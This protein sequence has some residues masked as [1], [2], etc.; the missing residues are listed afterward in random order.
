MYK[1]L[2]CVA[3]LLIVMLIGYQIFLI[4]KIVEWGS[5]HLFQLLNRCLLGIVTKYYGLFLA[6]DKNI[7]KFSSGTLLAVPDI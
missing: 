3:G 5:E 2:F 6:I 7:Y 1:F 4:A